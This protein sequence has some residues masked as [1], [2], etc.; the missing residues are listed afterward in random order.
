[1]KYVAVGVVISS[2]VRFAWDL[3]QSIESTR[4]FCDDLKNYD[5][6]EG[7]DLSWFWYIFEPVRF[8]YLLPYVIICDYFPIML[9]ATLYCPDVSKKPIETSLIQSSY[10]NC[11]LS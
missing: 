7:E 3:L 11:S 8:I 4:I 5:E 6:I 9:I 1:M 10:G 2:F